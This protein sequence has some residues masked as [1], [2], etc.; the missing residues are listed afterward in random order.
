MSISFR[1]FLVEN[2]EFLNWAFV[3]DEFHWGIYDSLINIK[4]IMM[5]LDRLSNRNMYCIYT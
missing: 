4:M 2:V 3:I 1:F 5:W